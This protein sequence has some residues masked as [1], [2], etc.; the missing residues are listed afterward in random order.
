MEGKNLTSCLNKGLE[1]VKR[2][3]HNFKTVAFIGVW[4][5]MGARGE[6]GLMMRFSANLPQCRSE[7]YW[8]GNT[9]KDSHS[10]L[11]GSGYFPRL[12]CILLLFGNF[13]HWRREHRRWAPFSST[14]KT[15]KRLIKLKAGWS[16][17]L[18]ERDRRLEKMQ[19]LSPVFYRTLAG[20]IF[21]LSFHLKFFAKRL[22]LCLPIF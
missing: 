2:W 10:G 15:S 9:K 3:G 14:I 20:T 16:L 7:S 11:F 22:L 12:I 1:M 19:Q 17:G 4:I 8:K 18:V 21:P 6:N 5:Y 13:A